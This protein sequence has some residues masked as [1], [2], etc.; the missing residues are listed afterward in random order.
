MFT[1]SRVYLPASD[2]D[3]LSGEPMSRRMIYYRQNLEEER[4][5]SRNRA[6]RNTIARSRDEESRQEFLLRH[7][8][9]QARYRNANRA[10]LRRQ[11]R[12]YRQ[13]KKRLSREA[14]GASSLAAN[15]SRREMDDELYE[16]LMAMADD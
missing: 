6:R 11:S 5:K 1:A 15:P 13:S 12:E 16:R 14:D 9:A 10:K 4:L 8:E 3:L 7:R 2:E